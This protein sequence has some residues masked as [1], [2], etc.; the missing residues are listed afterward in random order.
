MSGPVHLT[1]VSLDEL[2]R[3]GHPLTSAQWAAI[4]RMNG[5]DAHPFYISSLNSYLLLLSKKILTVSIGYVPYLD[6][7][8][9]DS[10]L[11]S[12]INR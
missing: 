11:L 2:P 5:W 9:V 3:T 4:K 1:P 12:A 6:L 7:P 8:E 10:E